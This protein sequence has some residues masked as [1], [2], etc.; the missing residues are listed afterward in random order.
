MRSHHAC[1]ERKLRG[2]WNGWWAR[3]PRATFE[4]TNA[5]F[6]SCES[7]SDERL[8]R[9]KASPKKGF[10]VRVGSERAACRIH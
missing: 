9:K 3:E 1:M 6:S 4:A 7:F 8:L 10:P 2:Q 5:L